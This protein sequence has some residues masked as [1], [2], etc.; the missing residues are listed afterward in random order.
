MRS[1]EIVSRFVDVSSEL[2]ARGYGVRF[3]AS[4][5]SMRPAICDGDLITVEPA[6]AARLALGNV[7]VYRQLDRLFAHRVVSVGADDAGRQRLL[8]RGDAAPV[9]DAP[10]S[11]AQVLGEVVAVS[12]TR[13]RP[14]LR[15]VLG[16]VGR[17]LRGRHRMAIWRMTSQQAL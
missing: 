8:L 5:G 3:R 14:G 16:M 7:I 17:V 6:A 1:P 15:D 11:P 9:C 2:L 4:G 12:R 10:I 13:G